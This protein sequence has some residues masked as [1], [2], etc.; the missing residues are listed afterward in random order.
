MRDFD[1]KC[2]RLVTN[3]TRNQIRNNCY[4]KF[5]TRTTF[6]FVYAHNPFRTKILISKF[7]ENV[8]SVT[9]TIQTLQLYCTKRFFNIRTQGF[10]NLY[11]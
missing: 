2:I 7:E 1:T 10:N 9:F 8:K 4:V 3:Y 11:S 5:Y 6:L